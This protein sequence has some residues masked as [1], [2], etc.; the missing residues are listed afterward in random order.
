MTTN[1]GSVTSG[2]TAGDNTVS[3]DIGD[4]APNSPVTITFDVVISPFF[5]GTQVCNQGVATGSN[6]TD[7]NSDDPDTGTAGDSTCMPV[8]QLPGGPI[9][10]MGQWAFFLFGL[11]TFTV[12]M[13]GLYNVKKRQVI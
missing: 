6:F 12:F 11:T 2:N 8:V 4:V 7:V 9:P 1:Q 5:G 13:V 10:T 3:V